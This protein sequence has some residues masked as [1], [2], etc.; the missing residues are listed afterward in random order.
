MINI[1]ISELEKCSN[2]TNIKRYEKNSEPKPYCGASMKDCREIAKKYP[3]SNE[4]AFKL[5]STN[6]LEAQIVASYLFDV[7]GLKSHEAQLLCQSSMSKLVRDKL[8]SE[9]LC[10]MNEQAEIIKSYLDRNDSILQSVGWELRV[11]QIMKNN[12]SL[13]ELKSIL[14]EIKVKLPIAEEPLKWSINHALCAIGIYHEGLTQECLS[15][16]ESIGAYKDMKVS[17]GCTSAYALEWIPAGIRLKN[18]KNS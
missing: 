6:H 2:A 4:L 14:G 9:V 5:L 18:R 13:N 3:K 12:L 11:R 15:L 1:I 17:K 7:K 10:H 8:V 16:G